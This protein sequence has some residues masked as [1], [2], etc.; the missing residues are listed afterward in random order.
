VNVPEYHPLMKVVSTTVVQGR[1]TD[2]LPIEDG[3]VLVVSREG[4]APVRLAGA[5]L[6]ELEAGI[7]E[8]DRGELIAGDEFLE[9]L[10]RFERP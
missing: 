4:S 5:E 2:Q 1:V 9:E 3:P 7:A 10:R 8:A 6:A